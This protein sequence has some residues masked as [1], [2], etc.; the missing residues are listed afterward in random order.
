MIIRV[1]EISDFIRRM[2]GK[3]VVCFG[4]GNWLSIL[5]KEFSYGIEQTYTY[6]VD[7]NPALWGAEKTVGM[8]TI[9]VYPPQ[10][11]YENAGP[12]TVVL[13]TNEKYTEIIE[14][15]NNVPTLDAIEC[16]AAVLLQRYEFDRIAYSVPPVPS[17]WRMNKEMQIPKVIHYTWFSGE[18]IPSSLQ[19]CM[20]SWKKYCPDYELVEWNSQNYDLT[21]NDYVREA[22]A[23]KRW[24][25]AGDYVRLDVMY[26]YGGIYLDLDVELIRSIDEL[27]YNNAYCGY[28]TYGN[29][30]LGSG[31][32]A[33]KGNSIIKA[34][35][36]AYDGLHFQN[37][38]G[39]LNLLPSPLYQ[40]NTLDAYGLK[41]NGEFQMIEDMAIYPVEYFSPKS[42]YTD[43]IQMGDNTYSIHHF[44]GSWLTE[45]E[46]QPVSRKRKFMNRA[47]ENE[48][49]LMLANER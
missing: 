12:N 9:K 11:L 31:F 47:W 10:Y 22:V 42:L 15:L 13:V 48:K 26:R 14:I 5:S 2:Q 38:D 30:N 41:R 36:D 8:R 3:E 18:P 25:F 37:E 34:M 21:V 20:E 43:R 28:E 32:G 39:S 4:A 35:R 49:R 17:G 24:G 46:W 45:E 19:A 23:C 33:V 27:L 16:Y 44:A 6:V 40:S 1:C 7:S 29:I